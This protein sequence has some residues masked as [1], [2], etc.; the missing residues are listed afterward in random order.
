MKL[1]RANKVSYLGIPG[2][3]SFHAAKV[4]FPKAEL[5]N[6]KSFADVFD[7]V[8]T[9]DA[10]AAVIPIE[11]SIAGRVVDVHSLM[12]SLELQISQEYLLKIDHCLIIRQPRPNLVEMF[13][14]GK[15]KRV[16][17][18]PQALSQCRRF[19]SEKLPQAETVSAGDTASAVKLV[20]E[21][22]EPG[23][24]AIG[25]RIAAETYGGRVVANDIADV[26]HNTT[27]FLCFTDKENLQDDG[28]NSIT[29]L[30][31]Q[32]Q[33]VPGALVA[34]L[35]CFEEF[36]VNLMK[37]ETYMVSDEIRH[38]TFYVDVG[39]SLGDERLKRALEKL[40]ER[41][42]YIKLLGTYRASDE[43]SAQMGFLPVK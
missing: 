6:F 41:A 21:R 25:S 22:G 24:A 40:K 1:K 38:P 30:I 32:V 43:R 17:S 8:R 34:A 26:A 29:T 23:D 11:N 16:I 3:Y 33:H 19:I 36:G 4:L 2:S 13:D 27:R 18:H 39:A 15:I 28:E 37:L 31:F 42:I 7:S 14:Y 35:S 12:L 20:A 9:R 5:I 10:D